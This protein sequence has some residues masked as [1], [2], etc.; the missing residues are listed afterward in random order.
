[1]RK[2]YMLKQIQSNLQEDGNML[3]IL[4]RTPPQVA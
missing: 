4:G 3:Y 1:M 2:E